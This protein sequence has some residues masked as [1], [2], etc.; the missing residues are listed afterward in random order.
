M[1]QVIIIKRKFSETS[2]AVLC[3][4]ALNYMMPYYTEIRNS[5]P[6]EIQAKLD[7]GEPYTHTHP[8]FGKALLRKDF[9][10]ESVK[11]H[12]DFEK[13]VKV[14]KD[15]PVKIL[16]SL[17]DG[18]LVGGNGALQVAKRYIPWPRSPGCP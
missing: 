2:L 13:E 15:I 11:Y 9:A 1:R 5:L 14:P 4:P 7:S 12:I 3:S 10:E 16:T 8:R 6:A 17:D 18:L